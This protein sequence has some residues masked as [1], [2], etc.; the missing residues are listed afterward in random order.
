MPR[1]F[2]APAT[3]RCSS[4]AS[5]PRSS[6]RHCSTASRCAAER[7]RTR[8]CCSTA[9]RSRTCGTR[10][11]CARWWRRRSVTRPPSP[12]APTSRSGARRASSTS[13]RAT[14]PRWSL[15]VGASLLD[16]SAGQSRATTRLTRDLTGGSYSGTPSSRASPTRRTSMS[17]IGPSSGSP[18]GGR[19][20]SPASVRATTNVSGDQPARAVPARFRRRAGVLP[21]RA[22]RPLP[23]E[24]IQRV[25]RGVGPRERA[26]LRA[27]AP[28]RP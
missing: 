14:A 23:D 21:G 25:V 16:G 22:G 26:G 11:I 24:V 10:A 28:A 18:T 5:R 9:S 4:S 7:P 2:P 3:I 13:G 6:T 17:W 12:T 15:D 27:R 8:A 19:S 1:T 20:S